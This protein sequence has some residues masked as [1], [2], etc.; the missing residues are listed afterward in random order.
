METE[1][2]IDQIH[3]HIKQKI[4][5]GLVCNDCFSVNRNYSFLSTS[6]KTTWTRVLKNLIASHYTD[7]KNF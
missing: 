6:Y 5:M 7:K 4:C 3:V 2:Q 1:M